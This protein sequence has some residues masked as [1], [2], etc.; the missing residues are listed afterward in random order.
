MCWQP[1][2]DCRRSDT[3]DLEAGTR[4]VEKKNW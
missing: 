2:V 1:A 3:G 4:H